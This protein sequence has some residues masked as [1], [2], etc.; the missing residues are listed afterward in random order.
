MHSLGI[1]PGAGVSNGNKITYKNA[2]KNVDVQY[3][4]ESDGLKE[5]IV[6]QTSDAPTT[7]SFELKLNNLNYESKPDGSIEF[8]FADTNR[9]AFSIPKP[10]MY[11]A[12]DLHEISD[13]V[14]Q[15]IR[16]VGNQVYLDLTADANWIKEAGR[17]FPVTIDPPI[18][19]DPIDEQAFY[20]DTFASETNP[21]ANLSGDSHI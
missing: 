8:R 7:Y 19:T 11:E 15:T 18:E 12:G 9:Y 4:V 14:T 13:Q 5:E 20:K 3:T 16:K 1:T 17:K 6:L 21:T 2:F 10:F